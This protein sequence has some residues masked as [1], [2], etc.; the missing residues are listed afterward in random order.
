MIQGEKR[1]LPFGERERDINVIN[2]NDLWSMN[3][4]DKQNTFLL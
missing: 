4:D 3:N 2:E 1:E